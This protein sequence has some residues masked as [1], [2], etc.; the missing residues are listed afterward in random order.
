MSNTEAIRRI[1]NFGGPHIITPTAAP[2]RQWIC[3]T[4]PQALSMAEY[5]DKLGYKIRAEGYLYG[6]ILEFEVLDREK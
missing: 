6:S 2:L 1:E 5:A 3:I 4:K